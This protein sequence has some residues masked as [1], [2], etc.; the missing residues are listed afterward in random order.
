MSYVTQ[1]RSALILV[2]LALGT[3]TL[4][5]CNDTDS[6]AP[7]PKEPAASASPAGDGGS[8]P[9]PKA[10]PSP[11]GG[12]ASEEGVDGDVGMCRTQDLKY[13]IVVAVAGIDHALLTATNTTSEPCLL[14]ANDLIV[15]IPG[16]DGAAT[17]AGPT[18][19]NRGLKPGARAYA[20]I[21]FAPGAAED[22]GGHTATEADLAL[23]AA[24][25]PTTVPVENGPVN[26]NDMR[27]TSW[28]GTA[29]DAL[30]F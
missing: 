12:P 13:S 21:L 3:L 18:G 23:T 27:V 1:S 2:S 5:A 14:P 11:T 30:S 22:A 10:K 8:K 25:T 16:L 24:E 20:G 6:G 7:A 19:A 15:T 29:E 9:S 4:T 28:F 17:H 26:I